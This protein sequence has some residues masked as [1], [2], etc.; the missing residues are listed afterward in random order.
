MEVHLLKS[1]IENGHSLNEISKIT[2]KS[3]T[4]IRY[5]VKNTI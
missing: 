3:L 1:Y 2:K 4:T 5:W